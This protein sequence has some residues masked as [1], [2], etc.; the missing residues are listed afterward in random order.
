MIT[1]IWKDIVTAKMTYNFMPLIT[2]NSFC[3]AVPEDNPSFA[4]EQIHTNLQAIEHSA[5]DLRIAARRIQFCLREVHIS[6]IGRKFEDFKI[7]VEGLLC[8]ISTRREAFHA[9]KHPA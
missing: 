2:G 1:A 5:I 4:V 7:Y 6:A 3:A 9:I 8:A